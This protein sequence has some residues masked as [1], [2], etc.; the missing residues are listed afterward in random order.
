MNRRRYL[1]GL[2]IALLCLVAGIALF[3]FVIIAI[4][5]LYGPL[6]LGAGGAL[7]SMIGVVGKPILLLAI[8]LFL[9][10]HVWKRLVYADVSRWWLLFPLLLLFACFQSLFAIGN[11]WGANFSV[12]LVTTPH[13]HYFLYKLLAMLIFLVFPAFL[14]DREVLGVLHSP[15]HKA[16]GSLWGV[17][18]L[19]ATL[20]VLLV[21][22]DILR[23]ISIMA[24]PLAM[25][26]IRLPSLAHMPSLEF[27]TTYS[28]TVRI[29]PWPLRSL[30][31]IDLVLAASLGAIAYLKWNR[32]SPLETSKGEGVS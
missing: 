25:V 13:L 24:Y 19:A 6:P 29:L 15:Q 17:A 4:V 12:G 32:P 23:G 3:P 30:L 22:H 26:G 9:L 16:I 10:D 8:A 21:M 18:T 7:A 11:F 5:K 27:S 28:E 14:P 1:K 31:S 20:I 2:M